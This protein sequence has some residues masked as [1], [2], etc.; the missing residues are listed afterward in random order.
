MDRLMPLPMRMPGRPRQVRCALL[1]SLMLALAAGGCATAPLRTPYTLAESTA[2]SPIA[3]DPVRM[4]ARDDALRYDQ[5]RAEIL[6]QRAVSGLPPPSTILSLS[7]GSDKGAFSAGLLDAWTRRGDRPQFDV[8]TGVSTGALIAPFA[9]LGSGEDRTLNEIYTNISRKDIFRK[10]G[11]VGAIR[12]GGAADTSPLQAL[13]ARYITPAFLDRIAAQHRLGRRLFVV[14]TNLDAQRG[15]IWDMGAIAASAS[16]D[17]VR[18]FARVLLASSSIPGAFSP[19]LIDVTANGRRF[20]ELHVDGGTVGGFFALPRT[21]LSRNGGALIAKDTRIYVFYNGRLGSEF[22]IVP[23]RILSVVGGALTT[24]LGEIDR[25]S[26]DELRDFAGATGGNFAICSIEND[27]PGDKRPIFDTEQMRELY[28]FGEQQ[29]T[30][31]NSCLESSR[32][33]S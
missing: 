7:G 21:I 25:N 11:I 27:L 15:V 24:L 33:S 17:R 28:A 19:V 30:N 32:R 26:V 20:S 3:G 2:A 5:V 18:L 12:K 29:A 31:K 16:P 8:V 10:R 23:P 9:F 22:K 4:W 14:T 13:I 1:V 6:R